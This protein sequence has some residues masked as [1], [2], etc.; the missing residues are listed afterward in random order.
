MLVSAPPVTAPQELNKVVKKL[1]G[2]DS[3]YLPAARLRLRFS[4]WQNHLPVD[5]LPVEGCIE[6]ALLAEEDLLSVGG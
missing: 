6:L 3:S 5:A 1:E 4:M 2:L